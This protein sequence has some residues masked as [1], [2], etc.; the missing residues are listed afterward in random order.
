MTEIETINFYSP[1][2]FINF[3]KD[4]YVNNKFIR[5]V[6][7]FDGD[8]SFKIRFNKLCVKPL[9]ITLESAN[10]KNNIYLNY[11]NINNLFGDSII[12]TFHNKFE[13]NNKTLSNKMYLLI[14]EFEQKTY[15][16]LN[17]YPLHVVEC[18]NEHNIQQIRNQFKVEFDNS[19]LKDYV[20]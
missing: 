6:C 7:Y 20:F 5:A 3:L 17:Y 4:K 18:D 15:M 2:K 1:N 8:D 9:F 19:D 11:N 10:K 12:L 13:I 14:I 16:D